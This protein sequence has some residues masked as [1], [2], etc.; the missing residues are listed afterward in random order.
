MKMLRLEAVFRGEA[1]CPAGRDNV[2]WTC[3]SAWR[4]AGG[5][6]QGGVL[7]GVN[8][9]EALREQGGH[10]RVIGGQRRDVGAWGE[11]VETWGGRGGNASIWMDGWRGSLGSG[12]WLLSVRR[13]WGPRRSSA[14]L[15][16][17]RFSRL[18][19]HYT[20][21][22]RVDSQIWSAAVLSVLGVCVF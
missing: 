16:K 18:T 17:A 21:F 7:G 2:G 4:G 1:L 15:S 22:A 12:D 14:S 5:R 20:R 6:A 8:W 19:P 10:W 9:G 3:R 11:I 13:V